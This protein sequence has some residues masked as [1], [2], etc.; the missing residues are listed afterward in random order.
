[1]TSIGRIER[2]DLREVWP[3]EA[4][5]FTQWLGEN[6]DVLSEELGITLTDAEIEGAAGDFSV[7]V[8]ARDDR[9]RTVVIENQLG[10]SDH[11]HLGKLLT[12]FAMMN[13]E[14]AIWI[15][16]EARPEHVSA[17]S[18]LNENSEADF[19]LVQVEAIRIG[20]SEPAPLVRRIVGPSAET[21][22]ARRKKQEM[23][24]REVLRREFWSGLIELSATKAG[25][26]ASHT[27]P[28]SNWIATG[29]GRTGLR[30]KFDLRMHSASA[31]LYIDCGKESKAENEEIFDQLQE[32]RS[33]IDTVF[34]E[35]LVWE[36]L[37]DA[38]ASRIRTDIDV[39]GYR[40]DPETDWP[41]IHEIMLDA[42]IRL[43]KALRPHIEALDV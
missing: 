22:E 35:P 43:E 41:R 12:Y 5:D 19:Y 17:V 33:E 37:D 40:D 10:R 36:R 3:H 42:M 18:W 11:D 21:R 15:V 1:V 16:S 8:I 28:T 24:E 31:S 34:G 23:S 14:A 2:V 32:H 39:G 4:Y 6:L 30:Y 38:R 9:D 7:D 13:A 27:P 25:L 29:A 26:F 20:E